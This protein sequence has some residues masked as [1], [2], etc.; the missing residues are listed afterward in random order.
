MLI[1][2]ICEGIA[3]IQSGSEQTMKQ[4]EKRSC[5][6]FQKNAN[7][8]SDDESDL[9]GGKEDFFLGELEKTK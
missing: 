8:E 1:L 9:T 3:I 5:R 6:A 2:H 4:A 7:L